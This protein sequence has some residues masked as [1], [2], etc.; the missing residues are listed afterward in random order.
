MKIKQSALIMTVV[1][2]MW[3]AVTPAFATSFTINGVL[4][5]NASFSG[6]LNINTATGTITGYHVALPAVS[7][8]PAL[9]FTP[10]DSIVIPLTTATC[11][12]GFFQLSDTSIPGLRELDLAV[13]IPQ[14]TLVGF[15]GATII[16]SVQCSGTPPFVLNSGY[17]GITSAEQQN[18]VKLTSGSITTTTVPEPS[19]LFLLG[20]G[21]L[22]IVGA[23]RR[24]L[25]V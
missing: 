20:T 12:A 9:T 14:T 25:R 11:P 15:T 19:S 22:C 1:V 10:A 3:F 8:L 13:I 16:P 6:T 17:V 24:K 21:L 18:L 23:V 7:G 5:G 4:Q 2:A